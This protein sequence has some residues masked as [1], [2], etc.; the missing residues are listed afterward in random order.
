MSRL[1]EMEVDGDRLTRDQVL[2]VLW[3]RVIA[4]LD[5]VTSSL[6]SMFAWLAEHPTAA[7]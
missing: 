5:T 1:L 6:A 3:L 7:R 4:G 2:D